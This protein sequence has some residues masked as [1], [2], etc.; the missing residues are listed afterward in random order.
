MAWPWRR[1]CSLLP[2]LP[3]FFLG[4]ILLPGAVGAI[5]CLVIVNFLPQK[6]KQLLLLVMLLLVLPLSIA[7]YQAGVECEHGR[8]HAR[9]GSEPARAIR[10]GAVAVVA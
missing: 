7:T 3:L 2:V 1:A 8:L 10:H 4:F 6:K 5:F 9:R